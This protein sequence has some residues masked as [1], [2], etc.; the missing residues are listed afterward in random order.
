MTRNSALVLLAIPSALLAQNGAAGAN[1]YASSD[2]D[3]SAYEKH[4]LSGLWSRNSQQFKLPPCP[5]CR[6]HG[7]VPG[8]GYHG[9]TPARTPEGEKRFQANKPSRGFDLGSKDAKDH[10]EIDV[11]MRRARMRFCSAGSKARRAASHSASASASWK[12]PQL[13]PPTTR[14]RP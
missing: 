3:K 8:Y 2:T 14:P 11:G 6:E 9:K 13:K 4:D 7:P 1:P 10:P 12:L 5:E